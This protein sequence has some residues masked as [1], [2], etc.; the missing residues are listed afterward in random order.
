MNIYTHSNSHTYYF[1]CMWLFLWLWWWWEFRFV[2]YLIGMPVSTNLHSACVPVTVHAAQEELF[3][4]VIHWAEYIFSIHFYFSFCVCVCIMH[5][6]VY[7]NRCTQI[8]YFTNYFSTMPLYSMAGA[9]LFCL[10][11]FPLISLLL[12]NSSVSLKCNGE[13]IVTMPWFSCHF[14]AVLVVL[15]PLQR[16]YTKYMFVCTF[17]F[18]TGLAEYVGICITL[19]EICIQNS[20]CLPN[21]IRARCEENK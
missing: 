15:L 4:F 10:R 11:K 9:A 2:S 18:W 1:D 3:H 5:V 8:K 6:F 14:V 16:S 20:V 12:L 7:R 21:S 13:F 19:K 17:S